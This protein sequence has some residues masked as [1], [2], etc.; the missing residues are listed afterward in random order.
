[1]KKIW[2]L[3][4][5][6]L[7]LIICCVWSKK[8][9]IH[10]SAS[11]QKGL[12]GT[13]HT[14]PDDTRHIEYKIKQLNNGYTLNGHFTDV[15]QQQS[16]E[17]KIVALG[18]ALTI[19]NTSTNK[20]LVGDDVVNLTN[21]ILPHFV[22]N[23]RNGMVSYN[24]EKLTVSGQVKEYAV[25]NEMQRLLN[26]TAMA[27]ENNTEVVLDTPIDFE[28]KKESDTLQLGGTFANK[29]QIAKIT[30]HLRPSY[31]TSDLKKNAHRVDKGGIEVANKILPSFVKNYTQGKIS[32][33]E[34]ILTLEGTVSSQ[35]ALDEM[36]ALLSS[37]DIRVINNTV[38]D[39]QVV[40]QAQ[41]AEMLAQEEAKRK[42]LEESQ[43]AQEEQKRL[44]QVE[45]EQ[46][47]LA[48]KTQE[49]EQ[50]RVTKEAAKKQIIE[51]LKIENV[52][53]EVAKGDLTEKGEATVDKLAQILAQYPNITVEIAG[54]TD[55]DGSAEFNQKLSQSR[56]DTVKARLVSKG[57]DAD[58]LSAK[59]Y[60]EAQPLV[61]NTSDEN[62]QKNRRVEINIQ[63]EE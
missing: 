45:A 57:V 37:T 48:Q 20:T 25:K 22:K 6:F 18:S 59:G 29:K 44:A 36:S 53:F 17:E 26:T 49:E 3:L 28:I 14:L 1:M 8:D 24:R 54:H 52:E 55:S 7:L 50:Q 40:A 60:G 46:K 39:P 23:Y 34:N 61:P 35:E 33:K 10:L 12:S 15:K 4:L 47:A 41:A 9:T 32:Y 30:Q 19:E 56:V 21:K 5:L 51:L 13:T 43:A 58:R 31:G 38:L 63:G 42:A 62:K 27:T 11:S 16:F 2:F